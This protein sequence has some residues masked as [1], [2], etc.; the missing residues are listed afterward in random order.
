[1]Y[2]LLIQD[3]TVVD[4][5]GEGVSILPGH[6]ILVRG[7]Q[8]IAVQPTG[9][10]ATHEAVEII[11]GAGMVALPGLINAHAAHATLED[12]A[13]LAEH[14]V[15]VAHCPKT[16]LKLA[17]GIAPVVAM[18]QRG[19]AI[20]LGSDGAASNNTLDILE[21]MRLAALLQKH[22]L[23][24]ARALP[25]GVALRLATAQGALA[26]GQGSTL[27]RLAPSYLA[28]I[29]L[30]QLDG[31]HMQPVHN[32]AAALVYSARA[33]DID[34][35]IVDGRVLMRGRRLRTLDKAMITREVAAR[36]ERLKRREHGQRIQTYSGAK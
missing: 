28:D 31:A 30:L 2:D 12:M 33:S 8:I 32:V 7:Q 6:D 26:L 36:V 14:R 18:H 29:I 35:V 22:T 34:T 21:Q 4:P 10:V 11:P 15:G 1:M 17:A 19:V 23:S 24:D 5:Q 27:G 16:F 20:G 9:K 13:I 25:V 3:A